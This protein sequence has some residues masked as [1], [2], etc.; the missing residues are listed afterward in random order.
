MLSWHHYASFRVQRRH[1]CGLQLQ[2]FVE[3]DLDV[4]GYSE[5]SLHNN[6]GTVA[7]G[8]QYETLNRAIKITY[9]N[10]VC[11]LINKTRIGQ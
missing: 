1:T 6:N 5:S 4:G 8:A 2:R 7:A 11:L 9:I 10:N 3:A